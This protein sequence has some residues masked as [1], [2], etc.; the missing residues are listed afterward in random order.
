MKYSR[1]RELIEEAFAEFIDP[2]IIRVLSLRAGGASAA[3][4]AGI[5][6]RSFKRHG[7]WMSDKG[8]DGYIKDN[9]EERL[10]VSRSLGI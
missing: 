6:D 3:A 9:L 8:K 7:C 5:P 2:N 1:V 4:N 10:K